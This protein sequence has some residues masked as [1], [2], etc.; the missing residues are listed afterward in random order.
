MIYQIYD[1]L[2]IKVVVFRILSF[3]PVNFC[4][5]NN[6]SFRNH[7]RLHQLIIDWQHW[8][9]KEFTSK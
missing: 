1:L 6:R 8:N 4:W 9:Y 2:N 3:V 7:W 5:Q